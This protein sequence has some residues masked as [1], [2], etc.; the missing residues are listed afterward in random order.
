MGGDAA[1]ALVPHAVAYV[2]PVTMAS[3]PLVHHKKY[4]NTVAGMIRPMDETSR[5]QLDSGDEMPFA[6][7]V[8]YFGLS[9]MGA[10]SNMGRKVDMPVSFGRSVFEDA[11][12]Y[13][14]VV[15]GSPELMDGRELEGISRL[16]RHVVAV[17]R[18]LDA[19]LAAGLRCDVFCGDVDSV[20]DLGGSL[21]L[22]SE[23]DPRDPSSFDVERYDPHK[24]YTDLSLAMRAIRA[25]WGDAPL[26]CTCLS[27]G[28]ADH[29]LAAL[30]CMSRWRGPV[31]WEESGFSSRMLKA[32]DEWR[33][34]GLEGS[35]FS[36][37]GLCPES[38]VSE[39]GMEWTLDRKVVGLLEDLGIS[40]VLGPDAKMTCHE[41]T[42][43]AFALSR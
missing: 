12:P 22:K 21:V 9:R 25:R 31:A 26:I 41:G 38:V 6:R 39:E 30:G 10:V 29:A 11:L 36:F 35:T 34:T 8:G 37:V 42:V 27:G 15:G 28:R 18:G 7:W 24:D 17:D 4:K 14:L 40:N 32:G 20:S 1:T 19:L 3:V 2:E 5:I 43:A 13:V 33:L 23:S 16:C